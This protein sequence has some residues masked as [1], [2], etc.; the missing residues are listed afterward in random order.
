[1]YLKRCISIGIKDNHGF[2]LIELIVVLTILG[3]ILSIAVPNI[4]GYVETTREYVCH[5]N[6][7]KFEQYYK[8]YL[9]ENGVDH[10]ESLLSEFMQK[11][12]ESYGQICPSNGVIYSENGILKCEK[13]R[14]KELPGDEPEEVPYI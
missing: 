12:E 3:T 10:S 6:R 2:S 1:M 7:V 9:E 14:K 11:Y 8:I 4:I 13:H 5:F